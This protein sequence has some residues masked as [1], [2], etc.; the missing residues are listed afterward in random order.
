MTEPLATLD[1]LPGGLTARRQRQRYLEVRGRTDRLTG[2][3]EPEDTMLQP[4]TEASPVK[5]HLA[6]TTWFFETF[7]LAAGRADYVPYEPSYSYIFNSYYNAVGPRLARDR[8]GML[9]RPTLAEVRAYR[10]AIDE[11]I[12]DRLDSG[13]GL[14]PRLLE[15][16]DLGLHH[17][18]QH[19]E[20]I[21]T[22]L[23][24]AGWHNPLRPA[25]FGQASASAV[26]REQGSIGWA[27][28]PGGIHEIGHVGDVFCFDN[29]TPRHCALISR[30]ALAKRPA[31]V[32]DF[33][34]FV[35]DRGYERPELWLSDGWAV[36]RAGGWTA[37]IYWERRSDGW[38]TYTLGGMQPLDPSESL[39]HV[40]FYEADAF[41]RWAGCRL[42]TEAE[43]E[44]AASTDRRRFDGPFLESERFHPAPSTS[45]GEGSSDSLAGLFGGVWEWTAS[46]YLGYPG[47][48]PAAGALGEYNGKFMCN[49]FVLRG[50]SCATPRTHIRATYR[51]FF[52]P[53][54]RWQFSGVR[55]ARDPE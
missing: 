55:L 37:P 40:S 5:W 17:E 28:F 8:R 25:F 4:A 50:G 32:A 9:S 1:A 19:Q 52:P 43:W 35:E 49:Q 7:V 34:A 23:K 51:N 13:A 22:D 15:I 44:V 39:C 46:P 29:E 54:A 14:E 47:Y 41:A 21:L 2:H 33:Q 45:S 53:E 12:V 30:F 48:R 26:P 27:R 24:L 6:H 3:L 31:S 20:L 16:L 42:P 36:S 10:A 11:R 38:W 18:Q